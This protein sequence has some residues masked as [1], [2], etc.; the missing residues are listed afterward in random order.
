MFTEES[1]ALSKIDAP[2][3][4]DVLTYLN[5]RY[6]AV[7]PSRTTLRASITAAYDNALTAVTLE[8]GLASTKVNI[9]FDL[10][11][12]PGRRLSLLGVVAHYL[13]DNFEPPA[14][15][16]AMLRMQGSHTAVNLK[17]QIVGL[18]KHFGLENT[19]G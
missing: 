16:L 1:L 10:W 19:L 2:A 8:L 14:I 5:P 4:R 17:D 9:S 11:T 7:I 12:S 18:V 13:N 3:V 15:L 6:K